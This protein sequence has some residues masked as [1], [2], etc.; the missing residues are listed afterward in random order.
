MSFV[1]T[2]SDALPISSIKASRERTIHP[3]NPFTFENASPIGLGSGEQGAKNNDSHPH[4]D[5]L[6]HPLALVRPEVVERHLPGSQR[7]GEGPLDAVGLEDRGDRV[8][9]HGHARPRTATHVP[10]PSLVML[11]KSVSCS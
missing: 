9:H 5:Q 1:F 10:I 3:N 4:F 6:L 2:A 7:P 8:F 11:A